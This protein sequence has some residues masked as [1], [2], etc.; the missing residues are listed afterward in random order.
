MNQIYRWLGTTKQNFHQRLNR[1]LER[2]EEKEQL[3]V[4]LRQVREDHPQMGCKEL[5]RKISL[6]PWGEI[7][8]LNFTVVTD[9]R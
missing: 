5:Y 7:S 9:L 3:K 2:A 1:E 6:R 4:V 8:S